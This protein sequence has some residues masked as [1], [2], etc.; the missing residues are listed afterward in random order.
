MPSLTVV[1]RANQPAVPDLAA[2]P[3]VRPA[4]LYV[5]VPFCFHKCHYCDFYSITRQSPQRMERFVDLVLAE[6]DLWHQSPLELRPDTVFFGGGTPSLLPADAMARLL[7]GLAERFD[8]SAVREWTVEVNP[9]TADRSYFRTMRAMGVDRVSLGAQSFDQSELAML[10]RHHNPGDVA[11][12]LQWAREAGFKRLSVDLIY[13]IPG[14]TLESWRRS[15]EAAVA[16][17]T[18][19]LS[20]YGLTYEPNTTLAVRRRLGRVRAAGDDLELAMLCATRRLLSDAGR[21]AYEISNYAIPGRESLHNLGYWSG[22]SYLG[23]G[24]S[25]ASHIDGRRFRNQPHLGRW[26]EAVS[27]GRLPVIEFEHLSPRQRAGELAMLNLRLERG[28]DFADFAR[29][30][31]LD[32]QEVFSDQIQRLVAVGLLCLTE[33][34]LRLADNALSVADGVAGEFLQVSLDENG[35]C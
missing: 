31:G 5:H 12:A 1:D 20:C 25:A 14:Q 18:E 24:P 34:S 30:T 7:A 35:R 16:L 19:H 8:L 32:A 13:A 6:A 4:G 21:P 17:E 29:R 26:E 2:F 27:A 9:A 23:L 15:L 28:I 3:A 33:S 10:E 11:Q 22:E